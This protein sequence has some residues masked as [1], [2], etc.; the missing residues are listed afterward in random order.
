[1]TSE[2]GYEDPMLPIR[3]Q[4]A[5][6]Q[7][8]I[9]EHLLDLEV[10]KAVRELQQTNGWKVLAESLEEMVRSETERFLSRRLDQYDFARSQ[11][12]IRALRILSRQ[13]P[14]SDEEIAF[15]QSECSLLVER[16]KAD[17]EMLGDT[18]WSNEP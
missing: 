6:R 3:R 2:D 8:K 14:L 13:K 17:A 10:D 16:N 12:M 9:R 11:G 1:M 5:D 4:I 7:Q 18:N 15:R